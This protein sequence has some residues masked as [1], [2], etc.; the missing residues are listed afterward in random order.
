MLI[1]GGEVGMGAR[2]QLRLGD[3]NQMWWAQHVATMGL[4]EVSTF[5]IHSFIHSW[6][7]LSNSIC[8]LSSFLSPYMSVIL[9]VC[10]SVC[11]SF[12][13]SACLSVCLFVCLSVCL[14][15]CLLPVCLLPVCLPRVCFSF[16]IRLLFWFVFGL[17]LSLC[18]ISL[19][20]LSPVT[21]V[22]FCHI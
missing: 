22:C 18:K 1:V 11:L 3:R 2:G 12:C 14:S 4:D 17:F 20:Y 9:A 21:V 6:E 8:F 7:L 13:L 19:Y 16:V 15:V 5:S 10:H